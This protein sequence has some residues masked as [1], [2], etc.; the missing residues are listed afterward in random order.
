[1]SIP[2]RRTCYVQ[3]VAAFVNYDSIGVIT[4]WLEKGCSA[5]E[6]VIQSPKTTNH[7]CFSLTHMILYSF[8]NKT[9]QTE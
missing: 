2:V 7:V 4:V 5:S 8:V 1:M 9:Q 6:G 3:L